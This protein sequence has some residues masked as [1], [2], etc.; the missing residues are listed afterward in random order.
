MNEIEFHFDFGS[1]NAYLAHRVIPEIERRAGAHFRYVP[2]LLGG[3]FK[4]TGNRSPAEAFRDIPSKRAYMELETRRFLE[5]HGIADF[6]RNPF[7]P[8]NTLAL[9]RG[10]VAARHEGC[11]ERY[12]EAMFRA[13]W[14]EPKKLDEPEIIR[15]ALAA[16]GLDASRL[17]ERAQSAEVKQE[18]ARNTEASVARGTFGSPTFFVGDEIFFGKD[19]LRNVEAAALRRG[20]AAPAATHD[21]RTGAIAPAGAA[22]CERLLREWMEALN[23]HDAAGMEACMRFPH[24]RLAA[25]KVAVYDAPGSNPM[26][27]FQRLMREEGWHHSAWT[28]IRLLQSS[29][30]KAHYA[31]QYARYREDGSAIGVYDSL[32]VFTAEGDEWKLQCRSSFG[33]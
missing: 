7:F 31:V 32:Y 20:A 3:V 11:F 18:L 1:P 23:R 24:V 5:E 22:Q 28:E 4:A 14:V 9:M 30:T 2:I 19:Q 10:A 15:D 8:V 25:G 27:L 6:R 13:M 12:V 26:D 16:S 17:L 33:P 21:A 29:P